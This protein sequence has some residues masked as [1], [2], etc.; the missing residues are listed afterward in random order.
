MLF[1]KIKSYNVC[2]IKYSSILEIFPECK[3]DLDIIRDSFN[4]YYFSPISLFLEKLNYY[5]DQYPI[6]EEQE[7]NLGEIKLLLSNDCYK[8]CLLNI[9]E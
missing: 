8:N 5:M 4:K 7:D 9:N 6:T 1:T 2:V 3:I